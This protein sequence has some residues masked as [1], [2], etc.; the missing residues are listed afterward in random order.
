VSLA[1]RPPVD[2]DADAIGATLVAAA[3]A[4]WAAF[5]GERRIVAANAG[6]AH[7]ADLV[8]VDEHGV[9]GFVAYR[10]VFAAA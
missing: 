4:A 9:L 2:A 3:T 1:I 8:A 5:L 7:P 6:R 10:D